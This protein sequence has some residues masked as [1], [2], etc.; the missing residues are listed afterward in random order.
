MPREGINAALAAGHNCR[1][2]ICW[3]SYL[4]LKI[5]PAFVRSQLPRNL[6]G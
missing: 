4:L 5:L 1:R 2:L 3:L 6:F